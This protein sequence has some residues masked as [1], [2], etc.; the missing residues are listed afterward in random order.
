MLEDQADKLRVLLPI[1]ERANEPRDDGSLQPG[2]LLRV[3]ASL[4]QELRD[5]GVVGCPF[6]ENVG[7]P[8]EDVARALL[9]G[10]HDVHEADA[11]LRFGAVDAADG[12]EASGGP[13]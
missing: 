7:A 13:G 3:Q 6:D 9:V 1:T 8:R 5:A 12:W 2:E 10:A 11:V 4:V